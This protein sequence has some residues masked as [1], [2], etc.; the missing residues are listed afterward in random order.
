MK[1]ILPISEMIGRI[2]SPQQ[3]DRSKTYRPTAHY[4]SVPDD[5]GILLFH[6]MTGELLFLEPGETWETCREDLVAHRFL[7]PNDVD[8]NKTVRDLRAMLSF[9]LRKKPVTHFTVFTTTDCNARC[10]YCYEQG[11]SR[12][13][14][15]PKAAHDTAAYI[16][17]VS[18]GESVKLRWFG[19][20][21][22]LNIEAIR[23]I[24]K[25]LSE[26]G[27]PFSSSIVTN[28]LYLTEPIIQEAIQNWNLQKAQITLDGTAPVYNRV[29]AYVDAVEDPYT[30]VLANI[31]SCLYAGIRVTIRLNVSEQ[32]AAD[33]L[34]LCDELARRFSDR[35]GL[36]VYVSP[37]LNRTGQSKEANQNAV[38]RIEQ[39]LL[40]AGLMRPGKLSNKFIMNRCM[41]DDDGSVTILPDGRIGKCEH[42]SESEAIGSI[43]D[44][45]LDSDALR[46]WKAH[47]D[48]QP[49]C[50]DCP[51]YP[52]CIRLRK[53]E[54]EQ[55]GCSEADRQRE[56]QR[57]K[58][59]IAAFK[60]T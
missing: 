24:C 55:F 39:K 60:Q 53:C 51:L 40:H 42:F 9:M 15:N 52:R 19:G 46:S 48:E 35:N 57:L 45:H 1:T 49:E 14:M 43:Y 36:H 20:E 21:P 58:S 3:Y 23:I 18:E 47:A 28:G 30:Q 29:K 8:E 37:I 4:L 10:F 34:T 38:L 13:P 6:T 16:L 59:R 25:V 17:R 44:D 2:V 32:N 50:K 11:R 26:S 5:K 7:V 56:I 54:W 22:L 12:I 27:K 31:E 41:A 33:M